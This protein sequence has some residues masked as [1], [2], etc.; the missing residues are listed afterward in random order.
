MLATELPFRKV[1]GVELNGELA[2]IAQHNLKRWMQFVRPRA[3]ARVVHQDVED[4]PWPRPP[5]LL[6]L[7]NPFDCALI[8]HLADKLEGVAERGPDLIDLLYVNPG[9]ADTLTRHSNFKVLWDAQIEMDAPDRQADPY[10]AIAD[11]VACFRHV[12]P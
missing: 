8:E 5:L 9:C 6:F 2:R 3:K 1:I 11:R 4:F 7:N 12:K 10:G